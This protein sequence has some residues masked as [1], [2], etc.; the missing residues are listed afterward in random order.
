MK[1]TLQ[2]LNSICGTYQGEGTNHE[3]Q[4]FNAIFKLKPL[5][6]GK[7]FSLQFTATGKDGTVFHK[8][9]STLAL[10]LNEKLTLWNF[11]TNS[12]ALIAHELKTSAIRP[13]CKASLLFGFNEISDVKSFREEVALDI[14][15][16][17]EVSYTYSWAMPGG[18]FKERSSVRMKIIKMPKDKVEFLSANIIVSKNPKQLSAF[19]RDILGLPLT[20]EKHGDTTPHYGCELGD[21]HFAIH[22]IENF[23]GTGDNVGSIK[24]AF[25][26]FNITEFTKRV[27]AAGVHLAHP[28]KDTGFAKMTALTDPD[29]NYLEFTELSDKWYAHIKKR[30][31]LGYDVLEQWETN[32]N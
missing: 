31:A 28:I 1:Q 9:E 20:E 10:A 12:P 26:V 24:L 2:I 4:V 11:N 3:D 6:N 15:N 16:N 21:L 27:E 17:G 5:F 23:K 29:G 8:E 30:R 18:E 22:P 32:K 13:D 14:W 19:Y 25:T 7:G